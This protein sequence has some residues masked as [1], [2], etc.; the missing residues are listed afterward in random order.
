MKGTFHTKIGTIK[1]RNG[2]HLTETEDIKRRWQE[3][4][5]LYKKHLHY[6]YN[7]NGV[8]THDGVMML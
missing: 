5:E 1:A 4:T 6:P 3:Y 2:M 7:H 8:I